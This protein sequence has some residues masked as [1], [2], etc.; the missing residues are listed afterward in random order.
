MATDPAGW[1][2]V[3]SAITGGI[4]LGRKVQHLIDTVDAVKAMLEAHGNRLNAHA[5]RL[6]RYGESLAH[7]GGRLGALER[8]GSR[9]ASG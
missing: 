4:W 7:H 9:G 1:V 3:V 6:D 5:T 8:T 2:L